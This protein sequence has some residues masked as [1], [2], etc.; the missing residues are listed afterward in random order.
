MRTMNRTKTSPL[1]AVG[2]TV[3]DALSEA[4]S[5]GSHLAKDL[6]VTAAERASDL[7]SDFG[8]VAVEQVSEATEK[9][10]D[11]VG[12][13]RD[14]ARPVKS[15]R[16]NPWVLAMLAVVAAVGVAWWVRRRRDHEETDLRADGPTAMTDYRAAAGT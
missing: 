10:A 16:W 7:A 9:V 5:S 1:A 4:W 12:K 11:V 15:R 14:R 13:A 2:D 8:G 3:T 6:A